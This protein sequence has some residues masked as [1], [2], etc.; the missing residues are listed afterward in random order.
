ME[1]L[2]TV[3]NSISIAILAGVVTFAWLDERS[4]FAPAVKAASQPETTVDADYFPAHFVNQ[5]SDDREIYI[6]QF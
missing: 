4:D 5:G 6:A 1:T 3:C 2:K